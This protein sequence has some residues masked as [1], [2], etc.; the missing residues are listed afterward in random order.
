MSK[1]ASGL[2]R[3]QKFRL[4]VFL[5]HHIGG[6]YYISQRNAFSWDS[7]GKLA[8]VESTRSNCR[9]NVIEIQILNSLNPRELGVLFY[10]RYD[11]IFSEQ[12]SINYAVLPAM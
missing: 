3:E 12:N 7:L 1:N 8:E 6:S 10:M 4:A 2:I 11:R 9:R 5:H